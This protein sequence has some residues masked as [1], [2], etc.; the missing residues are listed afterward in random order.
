MLFISVGR[1]NQHFSKNFHLLKHY[2]TVRC[3]GCDSSDS[4]G[5]SKKKKTQATEILFSFL[6]LYVPDD[7]S[8]SQFSVGLEVL[9]EH[10]QLTKSEV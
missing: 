1:E 2:L 10:L 5:L 4:L 7:S 3:H 6:F 9:V 8:W